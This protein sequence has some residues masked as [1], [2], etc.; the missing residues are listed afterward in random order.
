[1]TFAMDWAA[2]TGRGMRNFIKKWKKANHSDLEYLVQTPCHHPGKPLPVD[3]VGRA[4]TFFEV[5]EQ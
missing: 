2:M 4:Q 1:M 5:W 3:R